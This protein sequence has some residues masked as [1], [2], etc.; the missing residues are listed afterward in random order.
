MTIYNE[1]MLSP[2]QSNQC[3][4]NM[5]KDKKNWQK[6][7]TEQLAQNKIYFTLQHYLQA[8]LYSTLMEQ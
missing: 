3:L 8:V 5:W 1:F 7:I 2:S 6:E 4:N